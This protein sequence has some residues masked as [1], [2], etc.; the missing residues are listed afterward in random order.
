MRPPGNKRRSSE[1]AVASM[2]PAMCRGARAIL[3]MRQDDIAA[4]IGRSRTL[5][6]LFESEKALL[7]AGDRLLMRETF[8]EHGVEVGLNTLKLVAETE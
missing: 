2:T 7:S 1:E 8:A 4:S 5:I 6:T 3:Q